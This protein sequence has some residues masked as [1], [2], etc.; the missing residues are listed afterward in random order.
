MNMRPAQNKFKLGITMKNKV[1]S[2]CVFFG[3]LGSSLALAD[4]VADVRATIVRHYAAIHAQNKEAISS[5]HLGDFTMFFSDGTMLWER[6]WEE[7]SERMGATFDF[8]TLNVRMSNFNAQIYG[9]VAVATFYLVGTHTYGGKTRNV[10]NRVSAVWV[11][12]GSEWKEAHHHESP[13][14]AGN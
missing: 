8:G 11:K 13:L 2:A 14:R 12:D 3:L 4:D 5:H 1:I 7:V 6:D 10:T 9:N